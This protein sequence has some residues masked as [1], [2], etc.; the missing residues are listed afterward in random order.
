MNPTKGEG[1]LGFRST[2]G[3]GFRNPD[4]A[5]AHPPGTLGFR[6]TEPLGFRESAPQPKPV[7]NFRSATEA[8]TTHSPRTFL[9]TLVYD[10]VLIHLND[11]LPEMSDGDHEL[12]GET[13]TT[14]VGALLRLLGIQTGD[15]LAVIQAM[16]QTQPGAA[17][18]TE[19]GEVLFG[20]LRRTPRTL[21][22]QQEAAL[23]SV[24]AC[25]TPALRQQMRE[26]LND[27]ELAWQWEINIVAEDA[28]R[29]GFQCA[30]DPTPYLF[31]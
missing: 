26:A 18:R 24:Q 16:T 21:S 14:A 23:A 3:L 7:W 31:E 13:V 12:V 2:S 28:F 4:A 20:L 27:Y 10:A 11:R 9:E 15:W 6:A 29:L 17:L 22:E 25:T 5:P 19:T 30:K 8:D 1:K